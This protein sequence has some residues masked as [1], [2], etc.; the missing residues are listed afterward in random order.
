MRGTTVK[1]ILTRYLLY[2]AEE[3]DAIKR[4]RSKILTFRKRN[5]N[6]SKGE[7]YDQ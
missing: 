3:N 1:K 4:F 7:K 6:S 5:T 2:G